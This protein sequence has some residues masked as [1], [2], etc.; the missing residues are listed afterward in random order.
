[1]KKLFFMAIAMFC[2]CLTGCKKFK[3]VETP[4]VGDLVTFTELSEDGQDTLTGV[5]NIKTGAII[6]APRMIDS[7]KVMKKAFVF[8]YIKDES[9]T[10]MPY[11]LDGTPID[12]NDNNFSVFDEKFP[13]GS[14]E[15]VY[16]GCQ[17]WW[18]RV[19]YFPK[20]G[21]VVFGSEYY[22][23]LKHIFI[24]ENIADNRCWS[25]R[26]TSG[27]Q[28]WRFIFWENF[29]L[30]KDIAA[31]SETF[32]IGQPDEDFKKIVLY[33]VYGKEKKSISIARWKKIQHLMRR[34]TPI[35]R[36]V[37]M[38]CRNVAKI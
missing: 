23:G 29:Y 1:M 12:E 34:T 30:I 6:V 28:T 32:Y 5:K 35:G 10:L 26:T 24:Q 33:D 19:F 36:A 18:N 17:E 37:Y 11:R 7:I 13:Y 21:D 2:L 27:E 22:L 25:L 16:I 8:Y 9:V 38:E 14:T 4:L 3:S 31:Q 20:T 15:P